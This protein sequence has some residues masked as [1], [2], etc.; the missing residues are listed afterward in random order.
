MIDYTE[1][2]SAILALIAAIITAFVIPFIKTKLSE[3]QRK[4]I[5]EYVD[6]A[7]RAAEQLFPSVDGE[8]MGYEK[9]TYVKNMLEAKGITFDVDNV[10]DD[11]RA[12][13]ESAVNE[14]TN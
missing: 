8:K 12:M 6:V 5:K 4:R 13:I 14:F 10:N 2:I 7:V 3:A 1:I 9:L 11:I